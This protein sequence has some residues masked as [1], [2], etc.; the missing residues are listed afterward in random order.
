MIHDGR[1][2]DGRFRDTIEQL[3]YHAPQEPDHDGAERQREQDLWRRLVV[4]IVLG[5][6]VVLISMVPGLRFAGW[7][8]VVAALATPVVF[9]SGGRSTGP[10]G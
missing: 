10:P 4:A 5:V 1:A 2:D 9:W 6:P 7:E 8:W 3:G